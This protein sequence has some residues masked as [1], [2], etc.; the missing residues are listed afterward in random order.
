MAP[1][2]LHFR[3]RLWARPA[4]LSQSASG[5]LHN[6]ICRQDRIPPALTY[7]LLSFGSCYSPRRMNLR[8]EY[9]PLV[10]RGIC[11]AAQVLRRVRQ[12][13]EGAGGVMR[14]FRIWVSGLGA[15][16]RLAFA[17]VFA[18]CA[19]GVDSA[20]RRERRPAIAQD[21]ERRFGKAPLLT[22]FD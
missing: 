1:Q 15:C 8:Q 13:D 14:G 5:G 17:L 2:A 16:G 7:D 19:F 6:R 21:V 3:E 18:T 10:H 20:I 12:A 22:G 9:L 11:A 4:L